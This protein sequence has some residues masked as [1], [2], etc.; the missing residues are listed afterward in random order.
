MK[1][2]IDWLKDLVNLKVSLDELI[3]LIPL[4]TIG[5]KEVTPDFLE[6]DMKGYNRA[7]L[8]SLRGVAYE[9]AAI[10]DS[11]VKF[12]ELGEDKLL[13]IEQT[14]PS[15]NVKVEDGKLAPV[16]CLVK[17]SGLKVAPSEDTWVKKLADS[18]IRSVNNLADITNLV[19][20]EYGQPLHAFDA[21]AVKDETIVVR[22]AKKGERL[23]TLD[24][25]TRDLTEEDLLITDPQN[26]LGIAGVMGG[27][28]S[29]VSETTTTILLEAAI[30]NPTSIR[31]T[32][33]RQKLISE[34][35]KR[36]YHG[37]T[38]K[39]LFQALDAAI[40]MYQDL[41]GK[42]E[43]LTIIGDTQD[44]VKTIKLTQE[45]INSL[46][47]VDIPPVQVESFLKKL[48]F[49]L[50]GVGSNS[51][52]ITLPYFRPDINIEEDLIE[53]VARMYGYEK[54]PSKELRGKLP[55]K[56]DQSLFDLIYDLKKALVDI[57]LTEVQTYS[58]YSTQVLSTLGWNE[59]DR[60]KHL[61]RIANP[62]SSETEFMRQNIWPNLI[63]VV[64]KNLKQGFD[65]IAIFELGKMYC[66]N[67]KNHPEEGYSLAIALMNNSDSP[68]L[69]LNQ[70]LKSL[71]EQIKLKLTVDKDT[72]PQVS[73]HLFHP[74]RFY[75][76]KLGEKRVGGMAEVHPKVL[77]NFGI[78]KRVAILQ[79]DLKELI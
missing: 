64:A 12:E 17:I 36:F 62:I 74:T 59:E 14:F 15:L 69:E 54:I 42:L 4:R 63:E 24:G 50:E 76:L 49:H 11:Q 56:I 39:R 9:V 5:L 16:Y 47:G 2:S 32:A 53:E 18:G 43:G 34:A 25:K 40:K 33:T 38:Q 37:L 78:D 21:K 48:G 23:T 13:W 66:L 28:D 44:Q 45:K 73:S 27:K 26:A 67:E 19:M 6:L 71:N 58:F 30:F 70:M 41:G 65:D 31:R 51:W 10:T 8:L 60:K 57:G 46:I 52:Q 79:L 72:S 55:K 35:S 1:V 20:I 61:V 3:R 68:V 22:T 77:F 75:S 29:E 7:D